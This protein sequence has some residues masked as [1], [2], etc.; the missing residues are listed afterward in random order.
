MREQLNFRQ[1]DIQCAFREGNA[2][3]MAQENR[4]LQSMRQEGKLTTEQLEYFLERMKELD[5]KK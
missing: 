5:E 2:N 3:R 1:K 4:V